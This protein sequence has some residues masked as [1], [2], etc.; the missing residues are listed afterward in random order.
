MNCECTELTI[1]DACT[2]S[3]SKWEGAIWDLILGLGIII[4]PLAA[5]VAILTVRSMWAFRIRPKVLGGIAALYGVV[6]I[7]S[8]AVHPSIREFLDTWVW[9]ANPASM[10]TAFHGHLA[11]VMIAQAPVSIL[12]GLIAGAIHC[13]R[14][15]N[16]MQ[17]KF[18][19]LFRRT[20]REWFIGAPRVGP[21]TDIREMFFP[22]S[23][24]ATVLGW[25]LRGLT[26]VVPVFLSGLLLF[27]VSSVFSVSYANAVSY[28]MT[29]LGAVGLIAMSIAIVVFGMLM[30][31]VVIIHRYFQ[32]P[33]VALHRLAEQT[34][35]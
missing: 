30:L 9:A 19:F 23:T 29:P 33:E 17:P 27:L 3:F 34:Q 20:P 28:A 35:D 32:P 24:G 25:M 14:F 16:M 22:L 11:E 10:N 8:Q 1:C 12:L 4:Q 21:R 6:L 13:W 15:V 18:R 26:I 5:L 2:P 31:A 7:I